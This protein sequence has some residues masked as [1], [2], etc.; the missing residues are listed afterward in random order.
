MSWLRKRLE[1]ANM[2]PKGQSLATRYF[3]LSSTQVS[4]AQIASTFVVLYL[5][6]IVSW[7]ELGLLLAIQFSL[8]ALLDY[9]TGA[10]ADAI[11]HKRVLALAY[12]TYI[13]AILFLLAANSFIELLPWV[14]L[15]SVG[16]SQESG[17]LQAWF[18]NNYQVVAEDFDK[19]RAIYGAFRAKIQAS[20]RLISGVLFV[21]GGLI[22]GV[23]SRRVLFLCQVCLV[24]IALMLIIFLMQNVE[25][26]EI[27][28]RTFKA[29]IDRLKG[30][31]TF[32]ASSRGTLFFFL[33]LA[34]FGGVM[35]IWGGFMLFPLYESYAG[36][37]EAIGLLRSIL[38]VTGFIWFMYVARL[39]KKITKPHRPFFLAAF[40]VFIVFF[41]LVY[42][43]Y[44]LVPPPDRFDL[45]SFIALII[46]FQWL[47]LWWSL[48]GILQSRLMIEL[49]PN[50]YRNAVYSLIPT[51]VLL[52]GIPLVTLGGFVI[53]HYGFSAGVLM[54]LFF[55]LIAV[56]LLGLG[57]YWLAKAAAVEIQPSEGLPAPVQ[58]P[59]AQ[60]AG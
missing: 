43:F 18:D 16:V 42:G 49:V 9:P 45:S 14:V 26:V 37:D 2:N 33:G 5:L 39:S 7:A 6:D 25:G 23:F 55:D 21:V 20:F 4:Q 3:W 50:K 54:I 17:A 44:Q 11:G 13:F 60:A 12:T 52:I 56:T 10:L 34:C 51:L 15:A 36:A 8:T 30:G 41:G 40:M 24:I 1:I 46:L 32:F 31:V 57:L 29:Y 38:F 27:P 48:N 53:T 59:S 22:A 58:K 19:D 28:P 47:G 35:T